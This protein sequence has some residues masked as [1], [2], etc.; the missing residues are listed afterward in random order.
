MKGLFG[1]FYSGRLALALKTKIIGRKQEERHDYLALYGRNC[2]LTAL[3]GKIEYIELILTSGIDL[4]GF[5]VV[6]IVCMCLFNWLSSYCKIQNVLTSYTGIFNYLSVFYFF[7]QI[8]NFTYLQNLLYMKIRVCLKRSLKYRQFGPNPQAICSP[9]EGQLIKSITNS[10]ISKP[11]KPGH[12]SLL[13]N[14]VM[15]GNI[16]YGNITS[17]PLAGVRVNSV[18]GPQPY[19]SSHPPPPRGPPTN[20]TPFFLLFLNSFSRHT[21]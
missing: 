1:V 4:W 5:S 7:P 15:L 16:L 9:N 6:V 21:T 10:D 13:L 2:L 17:H 19:L 8:G 20:P 11:C 3:N 12:S 18:P 14:G